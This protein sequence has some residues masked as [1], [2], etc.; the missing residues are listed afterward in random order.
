MKKKKEKETSMFFLF[1][2]LYECRNFKTNYSLM[3]F[4]QKSTITMS[5]TS[6]LYAGICP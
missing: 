6:V 4:D 5:N 1:L 2:L 3:L